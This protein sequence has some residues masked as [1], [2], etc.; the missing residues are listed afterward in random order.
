VTTSPRAAWTCPSCGRKVPPH[1]GE[2]RCG[3]VGDGGEDVTAEPPR[4]GSAQSGTAAVIGTIAFVVCG[5]GAVV[6]AIYV[7]RPRPQVAVAAPVEPAPPQA[8]LG[9]GAVSPPLEQPVVTPPV[10]PPVSLPEA[11]DAPLPIVPSAPSTLEDL[12]ARV[13]PA[14]VL[15]ETPQGRGTGFFV[16]A[17]TILTNN[18]V[19]AGESSVRVRRAAGDM[20]TARVESVSTDFDL[21][22]LKISPPAGDVQ[23]LPLGTVRA[24]RTGEEVIAIGSALGVLQNS[25]TRGIVSGVRQLGAVT[26]V[27]TDASINPGNSG[28]PLVDRHGDVIGVTTMKATAAQGVSFAVAIDHAVPLL[29][30]RRPPVATG[31][32]TPAASLNQ[33]LRSSG[34]SDADVERQQGLRAYEQILTLVARRADQLDD[35][36]RR[37]RASCYEGRIAGGFDREWFA[38]WDSRAMQGAVSPGCGPMFSDVRRLADEISAQVLAAEEGARQAGVY[39]GVRRDVRRRLRLDYDAWDR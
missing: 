27:Q 25:V 8:D 17:D 4:H 34:P 13:S 26:V 18:H 10:I 15:I 7:A 2:C 1:I 9:S 32:S 16:K 33:T 39:P 38:V 31:A 37:F 36:W 19:A 12:V 35:Y 30:G 5:L 29:E 6:T 22:V 28:G 20:L 14:V 24:V 3:F 23:P 21:A 11:H